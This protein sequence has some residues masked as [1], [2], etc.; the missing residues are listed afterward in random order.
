VT[1]EPSPGEP[2]SIAVMGSCVTRDN[3]NSRFN[4]GYKRMYN[5]VLMQNQ[6]SMIS[7]MSP[8]VPIS[9]AEIGPGTAYD[10][11]NVATDFSKEFLV[12]LERL[13]PRYLILDFFGDVHFGV[14]EIADGQWVTNNRWKLWKTPYYVRRKEAGEQ[15]TLTL[16][17]DTETYLTLWRDAFD[18]FAEHVKRVAADT[19]VVVHR[20]RNA[21]KIV[22]SGETEPV[23]L[24]SNSRLAKIDIARYNELWS[25]LDDYACAVPGYATIDVTASDYPTFSEHPWGPY[26]VHYTLDYY[27][28]FLT[29]L[30][31]IHLDRTLREPEHAMLEQ[32]L[33]RVEEH[34]SAVEQARQLELDRQRRRLAR[35][36]MRLKQLK[37]E[38]A[39]LERRGVGGFARAVLRRLPH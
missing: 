26:F 35:Q 1:P 17:D 4:P 3:F 29:S 19:Q 12:E 38:R 16:Q 34:G 15:R 37:T 31:R 10:Q 22:L 30:N 24:L 27:A 9:E 25:L 11:W 8:P 21:S 36:S 7:L 28:D 20:G 18:R 5:T 32:V 13:Q 14:L 23:P 39:E 2:I 33:K 6:S